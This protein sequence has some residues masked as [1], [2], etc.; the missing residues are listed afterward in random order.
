MSLQRHEASAIYGA[1]VERVR[2]ELAALRE[3]LSGQL[4]PRKTMVDAPEHT[5]EDRDLDPAEST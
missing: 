4:T 5:P 2:L 1:E 3:E